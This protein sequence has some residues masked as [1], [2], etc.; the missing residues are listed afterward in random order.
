[1]GSSRNEQGWPHRQS[2]R[3][4]RLF[5]AP[6]GMHAEWGNIPQRLYGATKVAPFQS[7]TLNKT[8]AAQKEKAAIHRRKK[9]RL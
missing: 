6:L 8:I 9:S 7:C 1:M 5:C 2:A 3:V 4:P